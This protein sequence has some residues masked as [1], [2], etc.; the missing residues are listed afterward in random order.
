MFHY[1]GRDR[2]VVSSEWLSMYF[3]PEWEEFQRQIKIIVFN[4]GY[5]EKEIFHKFCKSFRPIYDDAISN[6]EETHF[7]NL[8]IAWSRLSRLFAEKFHPLEIFPDFNEN[9]EDEIH[10]G[11]LCL[12]GVFVIHPSAEKMSDG[13]SFKKFKNDFRGRHR[14]HFVDLQY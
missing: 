13:F 2:F 12:H 11:F 10:G 4:T 5:T 7:E 6:D 3:A 8:F 9:E 14:W 1:G